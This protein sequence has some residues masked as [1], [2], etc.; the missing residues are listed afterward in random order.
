MILG[1]GPNRI[2][3]GIEFDYCCCQAA[4]ALREAGLRN[5][6]GQLEPGDRLDRLRH[7]RPSVLRA[8]DHR[9]R[10]QH[11]RPDE[12]EGADRAVR[13]PDAAEPGQGAGN[14][15]GAD[16]RHQRRVHRHRRGP[17]ALPGAGGPARPA[18]SRPTAPPWTCSRR[19]TS[20]GAS[21]IRCWSG[22]ATSWAAGP[23]RSST[24]KPRLSRYVD[25]AIEVSPGKPILIDKFLESA[26]E[27]DVDCL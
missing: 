20:P 17:R 21:A 12:A 2:G 10:A 25:R 5:H 1:G 3:Q 23:W 14:G 9:G 18:S 22:P 26:I 13:R 6:H 8:A 24:T 11:L 7:Q 19:S 16:H 4:F 27:V 15:R